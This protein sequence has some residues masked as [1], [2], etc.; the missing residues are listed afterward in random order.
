MCVHQDGWRPQKWRW[1]ARLEGDEIIQG[2]AWTREGGEQGREIEGTRGGPPPPF[3]ASLHFL[4]PTPR[5]GEVPWWLPGTCR[6]WAPGLRG[7]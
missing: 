2:R 4:T 6:Q 7:C 1:E 3:L 5:V